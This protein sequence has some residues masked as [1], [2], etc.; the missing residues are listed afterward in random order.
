MTKNTPQKAI[1]LRTIEKGM[2][3]RKALETNGLKLIEFIRYVVFIIISYIKMQIWQYVKLKA[4]Q[5]D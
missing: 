1:K 2:I 4:F 3:I 5:T